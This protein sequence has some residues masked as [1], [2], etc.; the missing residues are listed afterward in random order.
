MMDKL[1]RHS[2]G[3]IAKILEN[4]RGFFDEVRLVDPAACKELAIDAQ[5]EIVPVKDCFGGRFGYRPCDNC[6]SE[7]ALQSGSTHEKYELMG[8]AVFRITSKPVVIVQGD[9][10]LPCAIEGITVS[11]I[12][13]YAQKLSLNPAVERA[14]LDEMGF[15]IDWATKMYSRRYFDEGAYLSYLNMRANIDLGM[16]VFKVNDH[17]DIAE[18]FGG[19]HRESVIK[20]LALL[21][22]HHIASQDIVIRMSDRSFLVIMP[23]AMR[24]TV[25][26]VIEEVEAAAPGI[27]HDDRWDSDDLSL[28]SGMA[29]AS[30]FERTDKH[31]R[32]LLREAEENAYLDKRGVRK[33]WDAFE[34]TW[35]FSVADAVTATAAAD[36]VEDVADVLGTDGDTSLMATAQDLAD[37]L[38][39]IPEAAADPL[40]VWLREFAKKDRTPP[41]RAFRFPM[42]L[43]GSEFEPGFAEAAI[44]AI[45]DTTVA[46]LARIELEYLRGSY[47]TVIRD[48]EPLMYAENDL[49]I[50][51]TAGLWNMLAN[52]ACGYPAVARRTKAEIVD[53]CKMGIRSTG[54]PRVRAACAIVD[55]TIVT[56]FP[57]GRASHAPISEAIGHLPEGQRLYASY[58]VALQAF[59]EGEYGHAIGVA[60]T[61]LTLCKSTYPISMAYLHI[62]SACA[63]M[64]LHRPEEAAGQFDAAWNLTAA[65]GVISPFVGHYVQLHGLLESR[66]KQIDP[67][68]YRSISKAAVPYRMGWISLVDPEE[69]AHAGVS[70]ISASELSV[71]ALASR[72]WTNREIAVQ[73]GL[74]VNT[75]KHRLSA[76]F[77][78][79]GIE[80]RADLSNFKIV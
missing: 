3:E 28:S 31:A 61:A 34:E 57:E 23:N 38:D 75:V 65:D 11:T 51:V 59:N 56:F 36:D 7:W 2:A 58:L 27:L 29:W 39:G 68:K 30:P 9:E 13:E 40:V 6:T 73:L 74:S 49:S 60:G 41:I 47:E 24:D 62:I 55:S 37:T 54:N 8:E 15:Y 53:L 35:K 25:L 50:R 70:T 80:R 72:G 52:M 79:L 5:G 48:T 12:S 78:K 16:I 66:L 44:D 43:L 17:G 63:H 18:I 71:A 19:D 4:L 46:S 69:A 42:P 67:A 32:E 33:E 64:A 22:D 26:K 21:I 77:Q 14:L 45:D 10:E 20:Q 76:V 1:E